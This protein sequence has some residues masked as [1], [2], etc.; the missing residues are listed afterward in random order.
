MCVTTTCH[1][2][3]H[4]SQ[5]RTEWTCHDT[6]MDES[7]HTYER[8][9]RTRGPS[10]GTTH[11]YVWHGKP[12]ALLECAFHVT[13][14]M[15]LWRIRMYDKCSCAPWM[16][17]SCHTWNV[18]M[19]HSYMWQSKLPSGQMTRGYFGWYVSAPSVR[20]CIFLKT[21]KADPKHCVN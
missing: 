6:P 1:T 16:C 14:K 17:F 2:C 4:A 5:T 10:V 7:C 18:W 12:V 3:E 20:K 19:T 13:H 11:S 8:V 9:I 15:C 21:K